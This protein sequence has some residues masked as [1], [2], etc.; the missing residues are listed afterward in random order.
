MIK[1]S[2]GAKNGKISSYLQMA[3]ITSENLRS[4]SRYIQKLHPTDQSA[5]RSWGR[6]LCPRGG[7]VTMSPPPAVNTP[8][9]GIM[10]CFISVIAILLKS[11]KIFS[12][13]K[14]QYED[15]SQSP[16]SDVSS[17]TDGRYNEGTQLYSTQ[18]TKLH[19]VTCSATLRHKSQENE[20][21]RV[22]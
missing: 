19:P 6:L 17:K 4:E 18:Q 15:K 2:P 5:F 10:K 9:V 21:E 1:L 3:N 13:H 12:S 7:H 20:R 8:L 11:P 16:L 14:R 22:D